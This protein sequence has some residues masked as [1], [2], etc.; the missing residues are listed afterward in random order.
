[1]GP[2]VQFGTNDYAKPLDPNDPLREDEFSA[3]N[4]RVFI[5]SINATQFVLRFGYQKRG[6][7]IPGYSDEGFQINSTI[8]YSQR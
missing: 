6:A 4:L 5:P 1:M 8:R 7:N 2:E 3:V